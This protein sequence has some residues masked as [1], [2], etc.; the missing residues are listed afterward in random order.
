MSDQDHIEVHHRVPVD[1]CDH[2]RIEVYGSGE[3]GGHAWR[4]ARPGHIEHDTVL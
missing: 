2:A 3:D 1:A 4:L